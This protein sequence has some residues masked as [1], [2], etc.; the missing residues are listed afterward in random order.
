MRT[1]ADGMRPISAY[2]SHSQRSVQN[3]KLHSKIHIIM[4]DPHFVIDGDVQDF[5]GLNC[6]R[7]VCSLL[8]LLRSSWFSV[9]WGSD[10]C[11]ADNSRPISD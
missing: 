8:V 4:Q 5:L 6:C 2:A 10:A 7:S 3:R 11:G 9:L 1:N